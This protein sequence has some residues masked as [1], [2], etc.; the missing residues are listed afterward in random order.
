MASGIPGARIGCVEARPIAGDERTLQALGV[1][2][3][4]SQS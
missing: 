4:D 3:G 2:L 1:S